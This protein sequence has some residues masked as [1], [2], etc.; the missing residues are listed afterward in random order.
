MNGIGN[1][2][3]V[4]DLRGGG[5]L[6]RR[7][8][9]PARPARR[10]LGFDQLMAIAT[11]RAPRHRRL[12]RHL[13]RRRLAWPAPAATARAASPGSC[14]RRRTATTSWSRP[15]PGCSPAAASGTGCFS[16]DMGAPRFGWRDIPLRDAV[17]DTRALRAAARRRT[18]GRPRP[19][20]GGQ[21]GQPACGLLARPGSRRARPASLG[22]ALEHHPMFPERANISF[23]RVLAPRPHP[24][25]RVGARRRRD[26]RLRLGR[27]R[28][29]GGGRPRGPDGPPRRGRAARRHARRSTGAP[30][31]AMC[32]MTGRSNS[33]IEGV[34]AAGPVAAA[35]RERHAASPGR[36]RSLTFGCRLN[37]VESDAMR[38]AATAAGHRDL[39][40]RQHLRGHGRGR[41][42]RPGRRSAA[43]EARRARTRRIVVTGCAAEIDPAAFGAMPEV[44]RVLVATARKTE[45]G[46]LGGPGRRRT[47]AC[48]ALAPQVARA[49]IRA[50]SSRSR[51]AATTA[52]PSASSRSGAAPRARSR[53]TPWSRP[54]RAPR[55]GGRARDRADRRR[56]HVLR[57]ATAGPADARHAG[58]APP[59][60][61]ARPAPA[62]AVV[63]RL[64][65]GRPGPD[66]R[67]RDR[68]APHAAPAS[69]A[70]VGLGPHPEAHEAAARARARPSRSAGSCA[71]LRP[72]IVFGADFIAGFPTETEAMFAGQLALIEA[73]G[74]TH[75]H[76]FPYSAAPRHAR[77]AHAAGAGRDRAERAARLRAAGERG[78]AP[79]SRRPDRA[80]AD[81]LIER[82]GKGRAADFTAVRLR[83]PLPAARQLDRRDANRRTV[84]AQRSL[85]GRRR[86]R[87][88]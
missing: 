5:A 20:L 66:R 14:S 10:G 59:G 80:P 58:A 67:D 19:G 2:I 29:P 78:P 13:Q 6:E 83:A 65:R 71:P 38:G 7:G 76:A 26:A 57:R 23:A 30:A 82:G 50:A 52:A 43:S 8:R 3:L 17:A 51:T 81:V 73:C 72:D 15:R 53:P 4:V 56:R 16:V 79:P 25:R 88:S 33:S 64:H 24:A 86:A 40:D 48:A 36:S 85:L 35:P 1:A 47:R 77:G 84:T 74:L 37:I 18:D 21:H 32:S 54:R 31:T 27:L 44:D 55:R 46:D 22:P 11:R 70:A 49:R 61:R 41:R 42:A 39:D 28:H 69:V 34:L 60:R 62:A 9:A 12:C 45:A 63:A 87:R 75:L 68:A